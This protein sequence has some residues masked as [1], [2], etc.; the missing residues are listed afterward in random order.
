MKYQSSAE[1]VSYT[2]L[3]VYKR[4]G[5]RHALLVKIVPNFFTYAASNICEITAPVYAPA[6]LAI[7]FTSSD[8]VSYTHLLRH[9]VI[10]FS[11]LSLTMTFASEPMAK[12]M[13]F[14]REYAEA[15]EDVYKRQT[16]RRFSGRFYTML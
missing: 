5:Y 14:Q 15:Y 2:H 3:D 10:G 6:A 8:S 4:Q 12:T 11:I 16:E 1:S 7:K 9:P 13:S